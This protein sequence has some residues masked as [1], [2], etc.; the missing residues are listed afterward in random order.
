M[1][2]SGSDKCVP[3][4]ACGKAQTA[5]DDYGLRIENIDEESDAVAQGC[6]GGANDLLR[7]RITRFGGRGYGLAA[8]E[9]NERALV[10][11]S[12]K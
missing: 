7:N 10:V 5:A 8:A 2:A 11:A 12:N 3:I 9:P 1:L 6:A 4:E